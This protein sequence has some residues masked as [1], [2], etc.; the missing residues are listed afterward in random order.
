MVTESFFANYMFWNLC[1]I[2]DD[3]TFITEPDS[4]SP[5]PLIGALQFLMAQIRRLLGKKKTEKQS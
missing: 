1:E 5:S 2:L 4:F 3:V